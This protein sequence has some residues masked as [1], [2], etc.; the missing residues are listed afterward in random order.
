MLSDNV[1]FNSTVDENSK[2]SF[3]LNIKRD[4]TNAF[5]H[6]T[7]LF[8]DKDGNYNMVYVNKTLDFC[9][10]LANRRLDV[11]LRIAFA[12]GERFGHLPSHCPIK[13]VID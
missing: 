11:V 9:A 5:V 12:V 2:I 4:Q 7:Y 13:K 10:F 8:A 3:Y 1:A 6:V